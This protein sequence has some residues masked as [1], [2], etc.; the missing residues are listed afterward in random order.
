MKNNVSTRHHGNVMHIILPKLL[1]VMKRSVGPEASFNLTKLRKA[2]SEQEGASVD[3][4]SCF[5]GAQRK[6]VKIPRDIVDDDVIALIDKGIIYDNRCPNLI[7]RTSIRL[8][9]IS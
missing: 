9:I 5:D 6:C 2:I 4:S 8:T 3:H 1:A 7:N